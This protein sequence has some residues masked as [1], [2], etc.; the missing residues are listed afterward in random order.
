ME[1]K[2]NDI[3][4]A[5][6]EGIP[7]PPEGPFKPE[8]YNPEVKAAIMAAGIPKEGN[9]EL[10]AILKKNFGY[11]ISE[12]GYIQGRFED[13]TNPGKYPY[14]QNIKG[15]RVTMP[16]PER[17]LKD[18]AQLPKWTGYFKDKEDFCN[19][20][21]SY[22]KW[23][24]HQK[25]KE[26]K[27]RNRE[28]LREFQLNAQSANNNGP[29]APPNFI[30]FNPRS[31]GASMA[32]GTTQNSQGPSTSTKV[33]N[34][35]IG[36][37][38]LASKKITDLNNL[39]KV[40]F[41]SEYP[42][43]QD[44]DDLRLKCENLPRHFRYC[45]SLVNLTKSLENDK[46]IE[47]WKDILITNQNLSLKDYQQ[48]AESI[49]D[50]YLQDPNGW[51][52]LNKEAPNNNPNAKNT[53]EAQP[54]LQATGSRKRAA[55][56]DKPGKSSFVP[57]NREIFKGFT[58]EQ[59]KL[60]IFIK[61]KKESTAKGWSESDWQNITQTLF[62]VMMSKEDAE[63]HG[64]IIVNHRLDKNGQGFIICSDQNGLDWLLT[65]AKETLKSAE[66]YQ[67][68]FAP[69]ANLRVRLLDMHQGDPVHLLKKALQMSKISFRYLEGIEV[70]RVTPLKPNGRVVDYCINKKDL[71]ELKVQREIRKTNTLK[72]FSKIPFNIILP[73]G[74]E[75]NWT[76]A[77]EPV[78]IDLGNE[79][80]SVGFEGLNLES[81]TEETEEVMEEAEI[82]NQLELSSDEDLDEKALDGRP[83]KKQKTIPAELWN[84]DPN[85]QTPTK[86]TPEEEFAPPTPKDLKDPLGLEKLSENRY[87]KLNKN[88]NNKI[89]KQDKNVD[90]F[91]AK[92]LKRKRTTQ[93]KE[94]CLLSFS[95][96]A[97]KPP[98][99]SGIGRS[100]IN[101]KILSEQ[102]SGDN[103]SP[104]LDQ[105]AFS[106]QKSDENKIRRSTRIG[107]GQKKCSNT[108]TGC[109]EST[110]A[111]TRNHTP[112][113]NRKP[114]RRPS[115]RY[116]KSPFLKIINSIIQ[117]P[118]TD[119]TS[120]SYGS[121][122][123][124]QIK[125]KYEIT[126]EPARNEA[127]KEA[128][129]AE[130]GNCKALK[131]Q[132]QGQSREPSNKNK[133]IKQNPQTP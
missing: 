57:R 29:S 82:H 117:S 107:R 11:I 15:Q 76:P 87:V 108:C 99:P 10:A 93:E 112:K 96:M 24:R 26:K 9:A 19:R 20:I 116:V 47:F 113:M 1:E 67:A 81:E 13:P 64:D 14:L 63:Q 89:K 124:V 46:L 105:M 83:A 69:K 114:T 127:S 102:K 121:D 68:N 36:G 118:K 54:E 53:D 126:E 97:P 3:Q 43:D 106:R 32:S 21:L 70:S 56:S 132:P 73:N 58:E 8:A 66:C 60:V 109:L 18:H 61:P 52:H 86:Q 95:R 115:E 27:R 16:T 55:T 22:W 45:E 37:G 17:V 75:D 38:I 77:K 31:A 39:P 129:N 92:N 98:D 119:N 62:T 88:S 80:N 133:K 2:T 59:K 35:K 79:V 5:S 128:S 34:S 12:E 90:I 103:Q 85:E 91:A 110:H 104:K 23:L 122:N 4:A 100:K 25:E 130:T 28:L 42:T 131:D 41:P 6:G 94:I 51:K 72:L 30:Q 123:K 125:R 101:Q 40:T 71:E 49:K 78:I 65:L 48:E 33:S 7:Y 84:E 120:V 111:T 44:G 74:K 50:R